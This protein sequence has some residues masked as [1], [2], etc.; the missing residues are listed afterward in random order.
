MVDPIAIAEQIV[1]LGLYIH[2]TVEEIKNFKKYAER[3]LFRI[4]QIK[5]SLQVLVDMKAEKEEIQK[6]IPRI[7]A[8]AKSLEEMLQLME[9]VKVFTEGLKGKGKLDKMKE[10]GKI[11]EQFEKFDFKLEVLQ[12]SIMFGV[13]TEVKKDVD[14]DEKDVTLGDLKLLLE[15][16]AEKNQGNENAPTANST[17]HVDQTGK[18][19]GNS[20]ESNTAYAYTAEELADMANNMEL[21]KKILRDS[22]QTICTGLDSKGLRETIELLLKKSA[23]LTN[24]AQTIRSKNTDEDKAEELTNI[25]KRKP[26]TAYD[27]FMDVLLEISKQDLYDQIKHIQDESGYKRGQAPGQGSQ[28]T[29]QQ[30]ADPASST[31]GA[32]QPPNTAPGSGQPGPNPGPGPQPGPN[33]GPGQP[34]PTPGYGQPNPAP[35]YG[36]FS[37]PAH[38]PPQNAPGGYPPAAPG[39]NAYAGYPQQTPQTGYGAPPNTQYGYGQN[40]PA[41]YGQHPPPGYQQPNPSGYGHQQPQGTGYPGYNPPQGYGQPPPN[42]GQPVAPGMNQ[43]PPAGQMPAEWQKQMTEKDAGN[44]STIIG[45]CEELQNFYSDLNLKNRD[46]KAAEKQ[47]NSTDPST[48]C[49]NVL[50]KWRQINGRNGTRDKIITAMRNRQWGD[51]QEE[52]EQLWQ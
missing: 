21:V 1:G 34:G 40:P 38:A 27:A 26:V 3:L 15:E 49:R 30:Q 48:L 45:T 50:L 13:L 51:E 10:K 5:P 14:N 32:G 12:G 25:L 8:F 36:Q 18:P 39:G 35:G 16:A 9:E 6:D 52:I 46:I 43:N 4:D 17:N 20:D 28:P 33:Q 23:L 2:R 41:G 44:I 31:T 11:K 22:T 24:D 47:A 29:M 42:Y 37:D 19:E 7:A